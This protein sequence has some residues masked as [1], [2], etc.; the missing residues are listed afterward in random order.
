MNLEPFRV[1]ILT[2]MRPGA[3]PRRWHR[4][5]PL[6]AGRGWEV[7]HLSRERW[8][9]FIPALVRFRPRVVVAAGA[10]GFLPALLRRW[11]L[12]RSYLVH[13]WID[14][15]AENM[16]RLYGRRLVS[17]LER[18]A[19]GGA[20]LVSSPSVSRIQRARSWSR[21]A[22]FIPHGV[23]EDFDAAVP[24]NLPGTSRVGYVGIVN[25]AKRVDRLI[26]AVRGLP[27]ELYLIGPAEDELVR[28]APRNAHFLGEVPPREVAAYIK[29]FDI[30]V[31]TMDNDS[32]VK[33][34]EYIRARRPIVALAGRV[35]GTLKDGEEALIT[36]DLRSGI[37]RLI[38]DPALRASL[39]AALAR[40][41]TLTWPEVA[42]R[43]VREVED[44][45][46]HS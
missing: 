19:V 17:G 45:I 12:L 27:C 1:L 21:K 34:V 29:A 23:E 24:K 38:A 4:L 5:P 10:I 41:E 28:N 39:S 6:L 31:L 40:Q 8:R 20:D 46:R 33:M 26:E 25:R 16:G 3:T 30:A 32:C 35:S 22:V 18:I 11:S 36:D 9:D 37:V 15:Y 13:D 44:Q 43:F 7:I 14:D 2:H 42:G